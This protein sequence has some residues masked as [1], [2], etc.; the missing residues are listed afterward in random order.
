MHSLAADR[1]IATDLL[2]K[3]KHSAQDLELAVVWV[4]VDLDEVVTAQ[5]LT[6]IKSLP[7]SRDPLIAPCVNIACQMVQVT[8][9]MRSPAAKALKTTTKQQN[10]R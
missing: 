9:G 8:S 4:S 6:L 1:V 5:A 7:V 3:A 2:P 10:L